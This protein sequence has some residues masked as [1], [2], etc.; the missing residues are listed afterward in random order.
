VPRTDE[1]LVV[2]FDLLRFEAAEHLA[3]DRDWPLVTDLMDDWRHHDSMP[4]WHD[5]LTE[6]VYPRLTG[7]GNL[8]T[9]A[10][11]LAAAPLPALVVPNAG[12]HADQPPPPPRPGPTRPVAAFLGTVHPRIDADLLIGIGRALTDW[13]VV[14]AGPV[15]DRDLARRLR[16]AGIRMEPWWDMSEIDRR[17]TVVIAPYARTDFTRSGDPLKVYEATARGVPCV[18]TIPVNAPPDTGLTVAD[19]AD[20]AEAVLTAR[21]ADRTAVHEAAGAT[22]SWEDRAAM[23]LQALDEME[24]V[25]GFLRA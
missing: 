9:S 10:T 15:M 22:G 25:E 23:I 16:T 18:S 1:G 13:D 21:G 24:S 14:V 12:F 7:F 8:L 3:R 20:F 11:R 5:H 2:C 19:P 4:A 17:A 6:R